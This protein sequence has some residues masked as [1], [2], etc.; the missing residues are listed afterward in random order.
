MKAQKRLELEILILEILEKKR[1]P[2]VFSGYY[3]MQ[4]LK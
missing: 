2:A 3:L 1:N 4:Y